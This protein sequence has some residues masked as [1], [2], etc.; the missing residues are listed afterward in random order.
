MKNTKVLEMLNDGK[1][2]ELKALLQ[3]EIYTEGLKGNGNAKKRYSAMKKYFTYTKHKNPAL[4]MPCIVDYDGGEYTSFIN[5]Y[6]FALTKEKVD[7]F[8]NG[9]KF[10]FSWHDETSEMCMKCLLH[11]E[12]KNCKQ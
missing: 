11:K 9:G 12:C 10:C 3:D 2:E 6:S 5:S 4:N 8:N 1:I 7:E